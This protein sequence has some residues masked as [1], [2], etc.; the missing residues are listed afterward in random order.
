MDRVKRMLELGKLNQECIR[1]LRFEKTCKGNK[2]SNPC[3]FFLRSNKVLRFDIE[4]I[5]ENV[6]IGDHIKVFICKTLVNAVVISKCG[7]DIFCIDFERGTTIFR[8]LIHRKA[9]EDI[10][11]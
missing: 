1:C 6:R 2:R 4:N 7:N 10:V 5:V 9:I 3:I 8:T 11:T